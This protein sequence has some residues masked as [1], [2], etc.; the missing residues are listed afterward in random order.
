MSG[1]GR[2]FGGFDLDFFWSCQLFL[3]CGINGIGRLL[4]F[5]LRGCGK[6]LIFIIDFDC[7]YISQ[8]NCSVL[9]CLPC[10]DISISIF[11]ELPHMFLSHFPLICMFK[12]V[13]GVCG[14]LNSN[15][16]L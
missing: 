10:F 6:S 4:S 7:D 2:L 12:I 15:R 3:R 13:D 8:K 1:F 16:G 14:S 9:V 11:R 5:I